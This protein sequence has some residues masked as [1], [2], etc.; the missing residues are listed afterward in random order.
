MKIRDLSDYIKQKTNSDIEYSSGIELLT[1]NDLLLKEL[2]GAFDDPEGFL[3]GEL[4][5]LSS[6]AEDSQDQVFYEFLQNA[7]DSGGSGLWVFSN[8]K[9][10]LL[11]LNDGDPFHTIPEITDGSLFSFLGKGKGVKFKDSS[12]SGKKG[13]GSK[14][15]YNLLVPHTSSDNLKGMS[16]RVAMALSK[17]L[18]APILFSWSKKDFNALRGIL[19]VDDISNI[20]V[21]APGNSILC[22]LFLSYFPAL[23]NQSL[24]YLG[25]TVVPFG[26]HEFNQFKSCLSAALNAFKSDELFYSPG[27]ILYVP[28][29]ESTINRLEEEFEKISQGLA[30]SLSVLSVDGSLNKVK[31]I[32]LGAKKI[33]KGEFQSISITVQDNE[34][35]ISVS[36]IFSLKIEKKKYR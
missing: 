17:D 26:Q 16:E 3:K 23:P 4:L 5:K 31:R 22:K 20:E 6:F 30:Q 28:A 9:L 12:K 10:G 29:H 35:E 19:E 32:H 21:E 27:T 18:L 34:Q 13:V 11:I 25:K 14:L 24:S 2:Y 15:M 7:K 8:P 1:K 33:E 36:F